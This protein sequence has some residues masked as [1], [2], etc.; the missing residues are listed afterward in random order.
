M[1]QVF[2]VRQESKYMKCPLSILDEYR[3]YI[4]SFA[5]LILKGFYIIRL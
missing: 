3:E 1:R 5:F 4:R 2:C